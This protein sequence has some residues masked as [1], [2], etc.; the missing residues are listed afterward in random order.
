MVSDRENAR[1]D[2]GDQE[3]NGGDTLPPYEWPALLDHSKVPAFVHDGNQRILQCNGAYAAKAGLTAEQIIGRPYWQILPRLAEPPPP[4]Q[5]DRSF[6]GIEAP[7]FVAEDGTIYA[8][9]EVPVPCPK[10]NLWYCRHMLE[11]VTARKR[12]EQELVRRTAELEREKAILDAVV[13][14]APNAFFLVD[15][16]ARLVRWNSYLRDRLGLSDEQLKDASALSLVHEDDRAPAAAKILTTL[17]MG[18]SRMELRADGDASGPS[19]FLTTCRRVV[20]D[21]VPLVAGFSVDI[22]ARK[23]AE[24]ALEE[25]KRFHEALVENIPGVYCVVD[26]EGNFLRWNSNLNRLTGLSDDELR[27][28]NS[29][30]TIAEKDRIEAAMRLKE[31][32]ETGY[33]KTML[34]VVS[35]DRG[36]RA[37]L[38]TGRR[39]EVG[40]TP[41]V[42]G[43][44]VDTTEQVETI[45]AL[46]HEARTDGLTQVPNRT[47]FLNRAVDEF[48]RCRRYGHALSLWVLDMDFFKSVNDK[49][50]HQAGDTVLRSLVD[51]CR[52]TLRDWDILGRMGGEEFG[53]LLPETDA[54]QALLVAERLRQAVAG[55]TIPVGD[56]IS[57]SVTISIGVA[58]MTDDDGDVHAVLSRADAL[59]YE[60][61]NTGR[62]KVCAG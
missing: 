54:Q 6:E 11:D 33:V 44:G 1:A 22:T 9:H 14:T 59:L 42:V 41:Y 46:E 39:F 53:V 8:D 31:V 21:G 30:L 5:P 16:D 23:R 61:K 26:A 18:T 56:G 47:H 19:H 58:T 32:F 27:K 20:I 28:R 48:A 10:G 57:V 60:A 43:V 12:L 38:M 49:H 17:A 4:C 55:T 29:I 52:H 37:F 62:N 24:L 51:T 3:G 40:G 35:H 13:E 36:E 7:T 15:K 25:Q 2:P 50:G 34:R 45:R